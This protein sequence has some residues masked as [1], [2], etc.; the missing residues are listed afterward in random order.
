MGEG[1]E[2]SHEGEMRTTVSFWHIFVVSA[3]LLG[4][5]GV[6]AANSI[7]NKIFLVKSDFHLSSFALMLAQTIIALICAAVMF[8]TRL[9]K[10]QVIPRPVFIRSVL[11]LTAGFLLTCIFTYVSLES[12]S[13]SLSATIKV[14]NV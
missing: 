12:I 9:D 10:F 1:L 11:P 6:S 14:G 7:L 13:V 5:Y 3:L 2:T 4:W 8:A